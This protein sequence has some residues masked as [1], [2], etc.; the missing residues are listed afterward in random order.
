MREYT[1]K[2]ETKITDQNIADLVVTAFE[3]GMGGISYWCGSSECVERDAQGQWR[4]M[5]A[6]HYD[7]FRINGCGPYTNPEFWDNDRR[8]YRLFDVEDMRPFPKVLTLA[9]LLKAM[10]YQP[11]QR[12]GASNNWFRKVVDRFLSEN[13]D[14][15]DADKLVQVAIFNEVVY[16]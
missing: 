2:S 5:S 15:D 12:N 13:Y 11:K 6:Q 3:G 9:S 7:S 8:G 14:A 16:G 10:Q 1:I 4:V